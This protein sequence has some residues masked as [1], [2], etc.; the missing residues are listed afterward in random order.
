M[1]SEKILFEHILGISTQAGSLLA[2][3]HDISHH[4]KQPLVLLRMSPPA[5]GVETSSKR[6]TEK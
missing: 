6:C 5:F 4:H 3:F 1:S 2:P